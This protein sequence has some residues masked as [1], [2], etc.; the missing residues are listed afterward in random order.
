MQFGLM[1]FAADESAL[2]GDKYDLVIRS[3]R[4]GDGHEFSSV[5]VP[6]RHFARLGCLYPN[7][8][9]LQAALARETRRIA[10]RAGSVVLPLHSPVR[11]AEE[12]AM[13]D[14]LS[15]G[16]VGISF[17]PGWNPKDFALLPESFP[18]RYEALYAG[19]ELVKKLWQGEA[20]SM[21]AGNGEIA[22][23]QIYPT[24]LQPR[25]PIWITAASSPKSFA[26]AGKLGAHLL[27]HL[28]DH[29]IEELGEKIAI[30][31]EAR[32]EHGHDPEQG[33]VTV[34]LHSF[35]GESLEQ[36]REEARGPYCAYLK[37]NIGQL[38]GLAR[39]RGLAVDV[40]TLSSAELDEFTNFLYE[41][42]CSSRALIG[43][44]DSC[45]GIVEHLRAVG[46]GEIASLL[47]FGPS[48]AQNLDHLPWLN[49]LRRRFA[50]RAVA[51]ARR[52]ETWSAAAVQA[53]CPKVVEGEDFYARVAAC[54]AEYGPRFRCIERLW[55]G[56]EMA[57]GR[58]QPPAGDGARSARY[59]SLNPVLLDNCFLVLG[60]LAPQD[61]LSL[62]TGM[63]Q[64]RIHAQPADAVWSHATR[65]SEPHSPDLLHG[66]V[67]I[68]DEQGR[69]CVEAIGLRLQLIER[70]PQP[71]AASALGEL[72]YEPQWRAHPLRD[73]AAAGERPRHWLVLTDAEGV[74]RELAARLAALGDHVF[75]ARPAARFEQSGPASFGLPPDCA[76]S[77]RELLG[78][79]AARCDGHVPDIVHA[80]ALDS[81]PPEQ[82][83]AETLAKDRRRSL[84]S[85]LLLAQTLLE[86]GEAPRLWLCT[87]GAQRLGAESAPPAIAQAPLWGFGRTLGAEHPELWGALVD[88]DPDAPGE[89]SAQQLAATL[90]ERR[91]GEQLA[92]RAGN[93]YHAT[94][95]R[96]PARAESRGAPLAV[97]ADGSY[98]ITGGLGDLGLAVARW[99]AR[100]GARHLVL[101]ARSTPPPRDQWRSIEAGSR[102]DQCVRAL[103]ELEELGAKV[104]SLALDVADEAA[105]ASALRELDTA[106]VPPVRGVVHA[107]GVAEGATIGTLDADALSR[108]MRPKVDGGLALHR[109]LGD[110]RL[111]WFVLFSAIPALVGWIGSGAANYSAANSFLD[112]LA[113]YRRHRHLPALSIDWG[114]WS[115]IGLAAREPGRLQQLSRQ[116][117]GSYTPAQGLELLERA[118]GGDAAQLAVA[119]ID[120]PAFFR[121]FPHAEQSTQMQPLAAEAHAQQPCA[122]PPSTSTR[123]ALLQGDAS[124]RAR[125]LTKYLREQAARVLEI[126]TPDLDVHKPLTSLGL[127]SL[128]SIDLRNRVET[129]IGIVIPI[130]S[131]LQGP[132]IEGLVTELIEALVESETEDMEE[133]AI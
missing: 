64:I 115:E 34:M 130:V 15:G 103:R 57:L 7:P 75:T 45:A 1:F 56:E 100:R 122:S 69:L 17:A 51:S 128:M 126:A 33:L 113:H 26:Q 27:T 50:Y 96:A 93:C 132:S 12:W 111:D 80:W 83:T 125:L 38:K 31:R 97:T 112:A 53:Q 124:A 78:A 8:A 52:E 109:V 30:Y 71:D 60:A 76:S 67:R 114:P 65:R 88:L 4:F 90:G 84:E 116:G 47:D 19:V 24:P 123:D 49:Q 3:A 94:M 86:R 82:C 36:V 39:S 13:V 70:A 43:T 129:E 62:P 87:R 72:V 46:V 120:W 119:S 66:D 108:V 107:A 61:R 127:D 14:N 98:L 25:L 42:F 5:W 77:W 106:G 95:E 104:H 131:L 101:A 118:L 29:D 58:L 99:L 102:L 2:A 55:S 79:L 48:P 73:G 89:E 110:A 121:A 92:W 10:L 18:R 32:R 41:R 37:A 54:G 6:E 81:A 35:V 117:I 11:V 23:V 22:N 16:R 44:P 28:L 85:T 63:R 68:Y 105:L 20:V 133:L 9:V 74:G 40:N 91:C 59:A 21:P